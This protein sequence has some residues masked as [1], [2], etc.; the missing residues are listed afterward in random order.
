MAVIARMLRW[1]VHHARGEREVCAVDPNPDA[2]VVD[3]A[4]V[5]RELEGRRKL[6]DARRVDRDPAALDDLD[7]GG[8]DPAYLSRQTSLI[9]SVRQIVAEGGLDSGEDYFYAA[10][11]LVSST[12][13]AITSRLTSD[14]RM[15]S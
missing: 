14:E 6:V 7:A 13:S 2:G 15:P 11:I 3:R 5:V 4:A 10:L 1:H 12:E 9:Q 8:L